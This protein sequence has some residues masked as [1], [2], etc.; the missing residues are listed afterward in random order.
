MMF[1]N[2]KRSSGLPWGILI[3]TV[4]GIAGLTA[5]A[6]S[7]KEMRKTIGKEWEKCCRKGTSVMDK[8]FFAMK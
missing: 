3:G 8:H 7:N 2:K 6:A 1:F 4:A 5:I